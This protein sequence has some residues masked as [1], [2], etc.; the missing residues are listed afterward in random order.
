MI[1]ASP[2]MGASCAVYLHKTY[3]RG[4]SCE[5]KDDYWYITSCSG[6]TCKTKIDPES[7]D[8]VCPGT[9]SPSQ[10]LL[11]YKV[12]D[13]SQ[14]IKY[15]VLGGTFLEL[16]KTNSVDT[17]EFENSY[18]KSTILSLSAIL[19]SAETKT[20][21]S[22]RTSKLLSSVSKIELSPKYPN[23]PA[24]SPLLEGQQAK[25]E[26][27]QPVSNRILAAKSSS[28]SLSVNAAQRASSSKATLLITPVFDYLLTL[29]NGKSFLFSSENSNN[30]TPVNEVK[31]CE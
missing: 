8:H 22:S 20:K 27:I 2:A 23:D 16:K 21:T 24:E 10:K 14:M 26:E 13:S 31:E 7:K 25:H 12:T 6:I 3:L 15:I 9:V 28:A 11:A 29:T 19:T 30:A 1:E 17:T 5:K 4:A 18:L